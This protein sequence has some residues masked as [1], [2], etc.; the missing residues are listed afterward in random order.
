MAS[1]LM[2]KSAFQTAAS[3]GGAVWR[4]AS[5]VDT[6]AALAFRMRRVDVTRVARENVAQPDVTLAGVA[7]I[8]A[9]VVR[10]DSAPGTSVRHVCCFNR[11]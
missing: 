10:F 11:E 7:A 5:M 3:F 1:S 8:G 6:R 9:K 4:F 2:G